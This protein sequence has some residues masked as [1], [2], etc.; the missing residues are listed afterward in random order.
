MRILIL[1]AM[2]GDF[3]CKGVK[4]LTWGYNLCVEKMKNEKFSLLLWCVH[5][6]GSNMLSH[7]KKMSYDI[8]KKSWFIQIFGLV[9]G[10]KI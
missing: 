2:V 7:V 4:D 5:V 1:G 10:F 3:I 6:Y 9:L 8:S